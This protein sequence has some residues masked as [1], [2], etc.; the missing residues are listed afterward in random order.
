LGE[1]TISSIISLSKHIESTKPK[2]TL[3]F[4]KK[5][6]KIYL[7]KRKY[8]MA[9]YSL[10][11]YLKFVKYEEKMIKELISFERISN[12]ALTDQEKLAKSVLSKKELIYL[13]N[14]INHPRDKL[15]IKL[16]YDTGA[17]VS[18]I[19][20]ITLKDIEFRYNEIKIMGK[21]KKPRT[22]FFQKS[23]SSLLK[24]YINSKDSQGPNTLLFTIKPIT[25]W[26]HL[27]KY[28]KALLERD[29]RP[30]M[31]RH[32]RLQ[33]MADEGVDSFLL[34]SYAGHSDIGTTQIYIKSSK[35]QGRIAFRKAGNI[36]DSKEVKNSS[37][38]QY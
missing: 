15:I 10:W 6:H 7:E 20:N 36:W 23:T 12:T 14:N 28:G 29:L 32:T 5:K 1:R 16:L 17:R 3:A 22:V 27:K 35:H 34:K 8:P 13:V 30:H 18:E 4:L 25:I 11:M 2:K 37:L 19:A 31:L 24:D 26:Y 33:H 9:R 21:G 38:M